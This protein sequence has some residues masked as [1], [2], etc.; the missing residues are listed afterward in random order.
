MNSFRDRIS[1]G[2]FRTD[3]G[4]IGPYEPLLDAEDDPINRASPSSHEDLEPIEE[5]K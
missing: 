5:G 3:Q 1:S 4:S 2:I